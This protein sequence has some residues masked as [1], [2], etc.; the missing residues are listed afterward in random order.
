MRKTRSRRA[1]FAARPGGAGRLG[2]LKAAWLV[3]WAAWPALAQQAGG[4]G[5]PQAAPGSKQAVTLGEVMVTANRRR[6]PSR[7][8]P[9]HVDQVPAER[10]QQ[11]GARTLSDYAGYQPGVFYASQGGSGQGEL[12]MRGISTGN[13]TSPTVSVYVDD[14]PVGGSTVYA[15]SATFL[16]DA[17]L[18]DLDHIEYLYGPQGTLY[19]AGSMGGLVKY[20]TNQPDT[21]AFSGSAGFDIS[22]TER[23]GMNYTE[24]ATVNL[25]LQQGVAALRASVFD[26]HTAGFYRAVG[27]APAR[28]SDRSHTQGARVQLEVDPVDKLSINLSAMGQR[29]DADGLSMADYSLATGRPLSG[30]PYHRRLN[31]REPYRQTIALYALRASYDFG[32][33]NLDWIS[34]YQNFVNRS[35]QDYPDAFLGLLNAFGPV[36]GVDRPLDTLYVDSMYTVHKT[37]QELRLTSRKGERVDW[38][39]GLWLNRENVWLRRS[40][41]APR[42]A[43][44]SHR[45]G[46][47][48]RRFA[49]AGQRAIRP[50]HRRRRRRRLRRP[51]H[52]LGHHQDADPQLPSRPPR[53]LLHARLHRLPAGRPAGAAEL[54]AGARR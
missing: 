12:I 42:A 26:Q 16:F 49:A 53:Q 45:R 11:L 25:P 24:R 33:A 22:H 27:E 21:G 47:R 44:G 50:G 37:S 3:A 18:M 17:A 10:L 9:M 13:Q 32:W 31:R 23:A 15:A 39:A 35:D 43:L 1:W 40:H 2:R 30:G 4:A 20:V 28:G 46:T 36:L 52:R 14:V 48:Q 6:E 8:V 41:L 51:P 29:I 54:G 19:G 7:E 5:E 38:L 34:S